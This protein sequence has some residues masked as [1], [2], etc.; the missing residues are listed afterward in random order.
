MQSKSSQISFRACPDYQNKLAVGLTLI[1]WVSSLAWAWSRPNKRLVSIT[2]PRRFDTRESRAV[3][4]HEALRQLV[5]QSISGGIGC[6]GCSLFPFV[7]SVA[8]QYHPRP[9]S[10]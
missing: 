9:E 2:L 1:R 4:V 10:L 8:R 3:V 5:T 6:T 7:L